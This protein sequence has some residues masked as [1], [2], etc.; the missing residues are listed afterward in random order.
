M[1]DPCPHC[2]EYLS[3]KYKYHLDD[4]NVSTLLKI[5][6]AVIEQKTN[7]IDVGNI[8]LTY[9]ERLRPTQLRFLGLIAKVKKDGMHVKRHW[10]IT[11]RGGKFLH[12][13][14]VPKYAITKN[15]KVIDRPKEL[16][17]KN[18]FK[19]LNN[20]QATYIIINNTIAVPELV[21]QGKLL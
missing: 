16:T 13:K 17:T 18:D 21:M 9:S 4:L 10:L 3:V 12:G 1:P 6:Q 7:E 14:P 15:N 11:D 20:F 5:W 19:I 2:G 8:N